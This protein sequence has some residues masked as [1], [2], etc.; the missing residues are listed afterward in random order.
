MR[1]FCLTRTRML[2]EYAAENG[3][4]PNR[5]HQTKGNQPESNP[6]C[7]ETSIMNDAAGMGLHQAKSDENSVAGLP[8]QVIRLARN[9]AHTNP[10]DDR[11]K[12]KQHCAQKEN[13]KTRA[14]TSSGQALP[15]RFLRNVHGCSI[16]HN[17]AF[18]KLKRPES[19]SRKGSLGVAL[20]SLLQ[21]QRHTSIAFYA[22]NSCHVSVAD[23]QA[24]RPSDPAV[25]MRVDLISLLAQ[26]LELVQQRP[27]ADA[28]GLRRVRPVEI[29]L[30]QR[31]QDSLP[32][33]FLELL[34]VNGLA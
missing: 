15:W 10:G 11:A 30:P 1:R 9:C 19:V 7:I 4:A 3:Q 5:Q 25:R 13:Q 18:R 17:A 21:K 22:A 27:P 23:W 24:R 16:I 6:R 31:F 8:W 34:R 28:Q 20:E 33:N 32:L 12:T 29:K 2:S 14:P 26:T